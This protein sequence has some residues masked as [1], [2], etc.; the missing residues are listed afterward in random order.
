MAAPSSLGK[1]RRE[2]SRMAGNFEAASERPNRQLAAQ[3]NAH[4]RVR[5]TQ[6]VRF[7]QKPDHII[8]ESNDAQVTMPASRHGK[9][10]SSGSL[11]RRT[12]QNRTT[13]TA[14]SS[15]TDYSS[16]EDDAKIDEETQ[17]LLEASRFARATSP[18]R[19]KRS[20][21]SS[22]D[23]D[24]A[25]VS[26]APVIPASWQAWQPSS[27]P[28]SASS[29]RSGAWPA[30]LSST[31]LGS[32]QP[33]FS[34]ARDTAANSDPGS[35]FSPPSFHGVG[36]SRKRGRAGSWSLSHM[37]GDAESGGGAGGHGPSI[38]PSGSSRPVTPS[39]GT[40]TGPTSSAA[41]SARFGRSAS[42]ARSAAF[43][44]Y[45]G[46]GVLVPSL[47]LL[48]N[49]GFST[50]EGDTDELTARSRM[51]SFHYDADE[52][53]ERARPSSSD[54]ENAGDGK[55]SYPLFDRFSYAHHGSSVSRAHSPSARSVG[56]VPPVRLSRLPSYSSSHSML[57]GQGP[58]GA[59]QP[60]AGSWM[61][62]A[63]LHAS[64]IDTAVN[65]HG[66]GVGGPGVAGA[67]T[68]RH[69][70]GRPRGAAG[71]P[72]GSAQ[73]E[74]EQHNTGRQLGEEDTSDADG[75]GWTSG[76]SS[77]ADSLV[78]TGQTRGPGLTLAEGGRSQPLESLASVASV[79]LSGGLS[80]REEDEEE[81]PAPGRGGKNGTRSTQA[82]APRP[83][84]ARQ[85]KAAPTTSSRKSPA[86]D[87][88][89]DTTPLGGAVQCHQ[90]Q[91]MSA[92][93]AESFREG[94]QEQTA[95]TRTEQAAE[96]LHSRFAHLQSL[97]RQVSLDPV[98]FVL[99]LHVAY[100]RLGA[101]GAAL[102]A[103]SRGLQKGSSSSSDAPLPTNL[104][105]QLCPGSLPLS[106]PL[107]LR[108]MCLFGIG[109][110][111]GLGDALAQ[112][113]PDILKAAQGMPALALPPPLPSD[114]VQGSAL[115][116]DI[117]KQGKP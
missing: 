30:S 11:S 8:A 92:P 34:P 23:M 7:S 98:L 60:S 86:G 43:H 39:S 41:H 94:Q 42:E 44:P 25:S 68:A 79:A 19:S 35:A 3:S 87:A 75:D 101:Q 13:D 69:R 62:G 28:S 81:A 111:G 20:R 26:S 83:A 99:R 18:A 37:S 63:A 72:A 24:A 67:G 59:G 53:N 27:H 85:R 1:D 112:R 65:G 110:A 10:E 84:A 29:L 91:Q 105:L 103:A 78:P 51:P 48:H 109:E 93:S 12:S 116:G 106:I 82:A 33:R 61:D 107:F 58:V 5:F 21:R 104:A 54:E 4:G 74:R 77:R 89:Q 38:R 66:A 96:A 14:A 16:A 55:S 50:G 117:Q 17:K 108:L 102:L 73:S 2:S 45:G 22:F 100:V 31:P 71:S 114:V 36:Q 15:Q 9:T 76:R 70:K 64:D 95:R 56:L 97:L 47:S 49:R 46:S 57:G 40:D 32:H 90:V 6:E 113:Y 115:A 88:T 52:D 80:D